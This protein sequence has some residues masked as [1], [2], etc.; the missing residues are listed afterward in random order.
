[1][2][3]LLPLFT[4]IVLSTAKSQAQQSV[5]VPWDHTWAVMHPMGAMPNVPAGGDVDF[6]ATWYL[7]ATDF[8]A[9]YNGPVFGA[10]PALVGIPATAN[11]YDSKLAQGPIGYGA[12]G[13]FTVTQTNPNP[14]FT[15]FGTGGTLTTP[16]GTA[17]NA[18]RRAAYFRTT[19]TVPPG[20]GSLIKPRIR[21]LIDDGAYIYL[22]GEL[23][24]AILMATTTPPNLDSYAATPEV[25]AGG[26]G[27]A[28]EDV[29]RTLDL[30]LPAGTANATTGARTIKQIISLAE[31]EHTL[32]ISVRNTV[33]TSSD[34]AMAVELSAEVGCFI[35]ATTDLASRSD[36]GTPYFTGDDTFTFNA[37]VAGVNAGAGWTSDD[38]AVPSGNYDAP[39][40]FGPFPVSAS[41]KVITFTSAFTPPCTTQVSVT[42][43][44]GTLQAAAQ[45]FARQQQGTVDPAD[46]TFTV[47]V[48]VTGQFVSN[49]WK[50]VSTTPATAAAGSP[51]TGTSG[52]TT[53][54]GPYPIAASPVTVTVA[55]AANPAITA[56]VVL[57]SQAFIGSRSFGGVTASFLSAAPLPTQ[58]V[59][60]TGVAPVITITNS[61]ADTWREFRSPVFDLSAVGAVGFAA[62]LVARETSTGSNFESV[63]NFRAKL[64]VTDAV[65]TSVINLI[66][67][68][69]ADG[70]GLLN[71]S[72]T[73]YDPL[74]DEFNLKREA[75]ATTIS[76]VMRME[77][78]V[79]ANALSVQL[80][81]EAKGIDASDFFDV[82]KISFSDQC[83]FAVTATGVTRNLNGQ[84]GNPAAHTVDF[85]LRATPAG[86]VSPTGWNVSFNR[87]GTPVGGASVTSGAYSMSIPVTGMPA[88]GGP[89][90]AILTDKADPSCFT[91]VNITVA[92]PPQFV[93]TFSIGANSTNVYSNGPPTGWTPVTGGLDMTAATAIADFSTE[94]V[95]LTGTSGTVAFSLDIEA[96]ETSTTSNFE[97]TDIFDA[98]LILNDGTANSTVRLIAPPFDKDADG[99]LKGAPVAPAVYDPAKDEF[100]PAGAALSVPLKNTFRLT[101]IIPDNIVSA[102]LH[103]RARVD[104]ASEFLRL[105]NVTW[106]GSPPAGTGDADGDGASDA[107]EALAGTD[108]NNAASVFR[109]ASLSI[110]GNTANAG[111]ATVNGKF[112]HG[113]TSPDLTHWT[114]DDTSVTVTGDGNPGTWPFTPVPVVG[115]PARYFRVAVGATSGAFPVTLP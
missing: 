2:K 74:L 94:T 82:R 78:F 101:Y 49:A 86:A 100:N 79:P 112:Y 15:A 102:T 1:M 87:L 42:P 10:A 38:P 26:T 7:K 88:D 90:T 31:G 37:T 21:Y 41:P 11:S 9:Q 44:G 20:N 84:P 99:I 52:A 103:L 18:N 89:I 111:F 3:N 19:F 6:D 28:T 71:G 107:A 91:G 36:N 72:P 104:V 114:R 22:D 13:Y 66:A 95:N 61:A 92:A 85:N 55:D 48:L 68:F 106:T 30:S 16:N 113:Y 43:P 58:W 53:S 96:E 80:V 25:L 105:R 110:S 23:I 47:S 97:D 46:D 76:N 57:T 27:T 5:L 70:N 93:G 4:A 64:I 40:T 24:S 45:S 59:A 34:I 32:A 115:M 33:L 67:P 60:T 73:P 51:A 29:L 65:G 50:I 54:F 63:D 12:A 8:A 14:E 108:P 69:D 77:A 81:V 35:N 39:T 62:E 75:L 56:Q 17:P 98:E 109:V 83:G